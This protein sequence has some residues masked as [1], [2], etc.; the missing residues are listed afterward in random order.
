MK[1]SGFFLRFIA[2]CIDSVIL[3]V[4]GLLAGFVFFD[5]LAS[6]GPLCRLLGFLAGGLY[7]GLMDS[8]L[9][10][11]ASIG[12]KICGLMV[13]SV[14][15][16]FLTFSQSLGRFLP[17]GLSILFSNWILG[18]NSFSWLFNVVSSLVVYG[19]FASDL[20]LLFFHGKNGQLLHDAAFASCVVKKAEPA[21]CDAGL[22]INQKYVIY[23]ILFFSFLLPA[24][25]TPLV[26]T[27]DDSALDKVL[28]AEQQISGLYNVSVRGKTVS[29]SGAI[30]DD[31]YLVS[32][33]V[34]KAGD[35]NQ[36]MMVK[37][38]QK[39][40]DALPVDAP[41]RRLEIVLYYG[42]DLG[43][44][45]SSRSMACSADV[46]ELKVQNYSNFKCQ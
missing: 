37:I 14:S 28:K 38:A 25:S 15:G 39:T 35:F 8:A 16:R 4:A 32:G 27:V 36:G 7:F 34:R 41:P 44:V 21:V 46:D 20:Y 43:V 12:K 3:A 2:F 40:M 5:K 26:D 31:S 1:K 22:E 18:L 42:F 29:T 10:K 6:M 33:A 11:G 17:V 23:A 13:V 24:V 9:F 19:V 30:A 45:R